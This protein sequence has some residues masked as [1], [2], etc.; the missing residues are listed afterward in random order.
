[1]ARTG[2]FRS[3]PTGG[4]GG[5][6]TG[7]TYPFRALAM[8]NRTRSLWRYV[9]IPILI[10]IVVGVLVY[11]GLLFAGFRAIGTTTA[12]LP[13][14]FQVIL[15]ILLGIGLLIIL[16]FLLVRFG[17]VLGSPW[18]GQ[19]SEH[20]EQVYTGRKLPEEPAGVHTIARD[21]GRAL[22][23]ELKKLVL[24]IAVG[25]PLLLL[26][27][28]PGF[29]SLLATVGGVA[30]GVTIA[31]LDFLDPPLER[32]RLRFRDKLGVIRRTLP[33]S[34]SFGLIC[35]GLITIPLLNLFSIPLCIT[36]GTLFFCD[37]VGE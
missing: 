18:Y 22:L 31:C 27:F 6:I 11:A 21:I 16:G 13:V 33:T 29:G 36:A 37:Q 20:L 10:N 26:N 12:D 1:M 2:S 15:Q 3:Q 30:L 8:I 24:V 5:L 34:A 17:V 4:P 32:R 9:V 19:L 14:A 23:Y 7:F 35:F 25:L 28:L